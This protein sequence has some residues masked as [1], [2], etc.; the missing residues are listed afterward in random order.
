MHESA[1]PIIV[2][3]LFH[4]LKRV[5]SRDN[6]K[7]FPGVKKWPRY[8]NDLANADPMYEFAH[9]IGLDGTGGIYIRDICEIW[10]GSLRAAPIRVRSN[11]NIMI[12]ICQ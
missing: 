8:M 2:P 5:I 10:K 11:R 12:N 9:L 6:S 1:E 3:I 7:T 4:A